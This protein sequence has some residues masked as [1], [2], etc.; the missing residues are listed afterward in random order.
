MALIARRRTHRKQ[1][2]VACLVLGLFLG[3]F[4]AVIPSAAAQSGYPDR[5]VRIITP[6]GPGGIADVTMRTIAQKLTQRL[7]R[8]F[9]VDNRPGAGG[10][11]AAKAATSAPPDGYTLFQIGNGAA[12]SKSL[13]RALPFDVERDFTPIS[14]TAQFDLVL[15]T[16]PNSPLKNVRDI[17]AAARTHPGQLNFGAI[18]AGSTQNLSA[19]LFRI[20]SQIDVEIITYRTTPELLTALLRAD[21]DVGFDY[22]PGFDAALADHRLVAIATTGGRPSLSNVPTVHDSGIPDYVVTG[23]NAL[24]GPA[25]IPD[26]IVAILNREINAVLAL[27]DVQART[28]AF[29]MDAHGTTPQ[30]LRE[31]M[32][33]DIEKWAAVIE[34]VGIEKQ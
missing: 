9:I 27:P 8:Q 30:E 20:A 26:D 4:A 11:I 32:Q 23:W 29:G 22:Y 13:F 2:P 1:I 5:P 34:K 25:G 21:V 14:L 16:R 19:E 12:I 17:I 28:R 18:A 33:H 24:A 31:R 7:G 15:V 6:Y 3:R 10:I